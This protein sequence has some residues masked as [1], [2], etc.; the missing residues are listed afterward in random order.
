VKNYFE[1]TVKHFQEFGPHQYL[2][3]MRFPRSMEKEVRDFYQDG[4]RLIY[5]DDSDWEIAEEWERQYF[6]RRQDLAP[7]MNKIKRR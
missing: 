7:D 4:Q 1:Y 5:D 2:I 6:Y 3:T